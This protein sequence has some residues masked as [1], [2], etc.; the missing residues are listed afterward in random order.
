MCFSALA[1]FGL[2]STLIPISLYCTIK[3]YKHNKK[4]LLLALIP[5][6]FAIQQFIE[7]MVWLQLHDQ[8]TNL[9]H[10][11]GY[12]YL[13][14]AFAFWPAYIPFCVYFIEKDVVR[15]KMIRVFLFVG[16]LLGAFLYGRLLFGFTEFKVAMVNHA[17][18]Y[19]VYQSNLSM[20]INSIA[21][22]LVVILPL[23]LSSLFKIKIYGALSLASLML[24]YFFY[25][26]QFSSVWCFFAAVLSI[27]IVFIIKKLP[28][29]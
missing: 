29:Y 9:A 16:P 1:S 26:Y 23:L 7:G 14:F 24:A 28:R 3:S 18:L 20:W 25:F 22:A 12:G 27:Y 4:F 5:L 11:Y 21:Y 15:K 8:A 17:I 10:L 2:G 13:F 19:D 6:F